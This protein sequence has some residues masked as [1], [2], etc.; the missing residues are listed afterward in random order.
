MTPA[1]PHGADEIA[2]FERSFTDNYSDVA[3][4]CARR[5]AVP[6]DAQDAATETF[7]IAWRRRADRPAPPEDRLWLFGI[8]RRVL[9]N[10]ARAEGR[11]R[12]LAE[13]LHISAGSGVSDFVL[14]D[15]PG[16]AQV[17]AALDQLAPAHR[18]LL[19]LFGWEGLSVAEIADVLGVSGPIV[20]RRLHR[21]RERFAKILSETAGDP[22]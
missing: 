17:R 9:A 1:V 18:E 11:R 4:Y 19:L 5:C 22:A 12:R 14:A 7:A 6:E 10:Q 2:A 21:A 13:R 8:A 20:S 15:G 16:S 3:R